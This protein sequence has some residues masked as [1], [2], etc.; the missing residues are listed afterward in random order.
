[1]TSCGHHS[2]DIMHPH[3]TMHD[4]IGGRERKNTPNSPQTTNQI[5]PNTKQRSQHPNLLPPP[6]QTV[7]AAFSPPVQF[8]TPKN[9]YLHPFL[10]TK[11]KNDGSKKITRFKKRS[12]I[13][14]FQIITPVYPMV[15][16]SSPPKRGVAI[17]N[18]K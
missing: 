8:G 6:R 3:D 9:I 18:N 11:R 1:M 7:P 4:T 2:H 15:S 12:S 5:L 10:L 14:G 17:S 13:F 16:G